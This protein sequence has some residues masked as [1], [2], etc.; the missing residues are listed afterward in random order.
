M[1]DTLHYF[2]ENKHTLSRSL[3]LVSQCSS[4]LY[5]PGVTPVMTPSSSYQAGA[6]AGGHMTTP[7]GGMGGPHVM[8]ATPSNSYQTPSG[9]G[10]PWPGATPRTPAARSHTPRAGQQGGTPSQ[11]SSATTSSG[12]MDWARAAANWANRKK[13]GRSPRASPHPSPSPSTG[14]N[15][16]APSPQG[17][18]TPLIDER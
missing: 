7:R 10:M 18:G 4:I 2:T 17:D 14:G 11:R 13:M 15:I 12:D 6:A 5:Q 8:G 3:H 16:T 1:L 9:S